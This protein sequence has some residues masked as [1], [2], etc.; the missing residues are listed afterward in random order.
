MS[1]KTVTLRHI[2]D[3]QGVR[4]LGATLEED[5]TLTIESQDL[6]DGVEQFFGPGNIEYEWVWTIPPSEVAK[7]TSALN[8]GS[9][10]LDALL[11]RFSN[12]AAAQIQPFLDEHNIEYESW[13]R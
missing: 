11:T 13:S 10:I 2:R 3:D 5:G 9:D 4:Y 8:L 6:G 12:E 1:A 7:L